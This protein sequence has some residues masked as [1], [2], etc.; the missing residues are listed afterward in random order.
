[1]K[2]IR[3]KRIEAR[4]APDALILVQRAAELQGRSVSEFV[5]T[6]AEGAARRTLEETHSVHLSVQDQRRF[7]ELL[8]DPPEPGPAL[9][10]TRE[11]HEELIG[12]I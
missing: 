11:A 8:L 5:V 1:M 6:A 7:V 12:P 2:T 4:I 9:R 10:R 3:S